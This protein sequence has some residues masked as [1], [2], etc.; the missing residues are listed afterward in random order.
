MTTPPT[1]KSEALDGARE[2]RLT[3]KQAVS[4]VETAA[5]SPA[6][7]PKWHEINVRELERLRDAFD[8]HVAEVEAEDGL[9]P[10]LTRSAPRLHHSIVQVQQEHP[11]I[12]AQIDAVITLA[13]NAAPVDD[14]RDAALEAL[15]EIARHRQRGADL[16]YEGYMVDIGGVG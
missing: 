9:L 8:E 12:C 1:E 14:V 10:E 16:V 5:A 2:R 11:V 4:A 6:A 13:T 7:D 15:L 3:L